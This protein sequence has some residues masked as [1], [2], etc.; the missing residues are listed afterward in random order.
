MSRP[1]ASLRPLRSLLARPV[2]TPSF[3]PTASAAQWALRASRPYSTA[4]EDAAKKDDKAAGSSSA[5]AEKI[6]TLEAKARGE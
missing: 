2:Q 5:E 3:A 6:A 1:I 4:S